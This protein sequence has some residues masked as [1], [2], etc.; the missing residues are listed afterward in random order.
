LGEALKGSPELYQALSAALLRN[1]V[2][3]VEAA[4]FKLGSVSKPR[5]PGFR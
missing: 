2:A 1:D 5:T 3:I 4:D